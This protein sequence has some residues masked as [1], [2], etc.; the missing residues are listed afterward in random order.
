[1]FRIRTPSS[2]LCDGIRRRDLLAVGSLGMLPLVAIGRTARA[3]STAKPHLPSFGRAKRCVLL[4][5]TG[6][7]PQHDTWDMKPDAPAEVRGEFRP[8][9]TDV[10]GIQ[11]CELFPKLARVASKFQIVRSVTHTDTVHTS[12][13]YTMLTGV[14]HPLANVST[15]ALIRPLPTDHPHFGSILAKARSGGGTTPTFASLP[16]VIKDAAVNEFPGQDAGFLGRRFGPFRIDG[17]G[18]AQRFRLPEI[19]L[20]DEVTLARLNERRFL[21]NQI[22]RQLAVLDRTRPAADLDDFYEQAFG[23]LQ[24]EPLRRAFDLDGEPASLRA[25]YGPHLFGQGCLLARRLL[26]AGVSLVTVYWHY[27]GPEDSPVWDTHWNN[28]KHLRE[29]LIPPTDAAVSTLLTDLASRGLLDDT[30]VICLGE[31]G[32]TPKIN[33]KA[34]RDHWPHVAS[35]LLAGAGLPA[36]TVFGASDRLGAY[37][38]RN[39]IVPEDLTAT[40][41]HL[42]GVPPDFE[43]LDPTGRPIPACRGAPVAGLLG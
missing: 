34:G 32:R 30:L 15:A 36:G 25:S 17:D 38:A 35:I 14:P 43:V 9:E 2:R 23:L 6:G 24:A 3:D 42:L 37:P 11:V 26:E 33:G 5:L 16:E 29:R 20:A 41:L 13:G 31:F 21:R 27:E 1:M 19:T 28:F 40:F 8:I 4:F 39:P 22:E 18:T 7:P 12:A 10:P